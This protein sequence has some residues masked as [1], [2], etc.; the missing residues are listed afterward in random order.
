MN[1]LCCYVNAYESRRFESIELV[2][3]V[4]LG[5]MMVFD[6]FTELLYIWIFGGWLLIELL[7]FGVENGQGTMP[8]GALVAAEERVSFLWPEFVNLFEG[9]AVFCFL[10]SLNLITIENLKKLLL[11]K[12]NLLLF[13]E[14]Y[15]RT[16]ILG[17]RSPMALMVGCLL[18][19]GKEVCDAEQ[20]NASLRCWIF[21]FHN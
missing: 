1:Y 16:Y 13:C 20:E 3:Y 8:Q 7:V 6:W 21:L 18:L 14:C 19:K 4:V 12:G 5:S 10:V 2:N 15:L 11:E 17:K 9:Y